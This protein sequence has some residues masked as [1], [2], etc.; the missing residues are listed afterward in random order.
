MSAGTHTDVAREMLAAGR[1]AKAIVAA[2]VRRGVKQATAYTTIHK[3][4]LR[5]KSGKLQGAK[6]PCLIRAGVDPETRDALRSEARARGMTTARLTGLLLAG[7]VESRIY[8][9]VLGED[10]E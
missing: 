10:E 2:L 4:R 5:P 7:I 3:A 9:A 6:L 8:D 1:P